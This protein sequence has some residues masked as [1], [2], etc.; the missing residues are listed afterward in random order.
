MTPQVR[1]YNR[2]VRGQ[3]IG[4]ARNAASARDARDL[5]AAG[6]DGKIREIEQR[7]GHTPMGRPPSQPP[8]PRLVQLGGTTLDSW[9]W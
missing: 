6:G 5:E 1:L 9:S 4:Q 8:Q 3:G 7:M 2:W